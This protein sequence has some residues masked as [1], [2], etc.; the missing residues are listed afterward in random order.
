MAPVHFQTRR[1]F[2]W[3]PY[4]SKQE[5]C[6]HG[7]RTFPNKKTV[8]MAPVHLHSNHNETK[9][10]PPDGMVEVRF[11]PKSTNVLPPYCHLVVYSTKSTTVNPYV[12][13][14]SATDFSTTCSAMLASSTVC[15]PVTVGC[16]MGGRG[17]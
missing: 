5:E 8:S 7:T 6:F 2:P 1:V 14:S 10:L 11:N 4:I 16:G 12:A 3:H 13:I 9:E 17:A 15:A